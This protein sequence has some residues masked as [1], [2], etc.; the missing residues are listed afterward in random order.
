[1]NALP[2]RDRGLALWIVVT[3][4]AAAVVTPVVVALVRP[5]VHDWD[6]TVGFVAG[7]AAACIGIRGVLG[8]LDSDTRGA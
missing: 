2:R 8:R 1:M 6:T 5:V 7:V 3:V 4:L